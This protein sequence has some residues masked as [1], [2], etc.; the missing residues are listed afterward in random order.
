[1]V[2]HAHMRPTRLVTA[3][4]L[5]AMGEGRRELIYGVVVEMTA[6]GRRHSRIAAAMVGRLG[7]FA[8]SHGLGEVLGADGGFRLARKPDLV[9][10]PD[11]SFVAAARLA[12][13]SE[14]AYV[15]FAPD[16]AV[17]VISPDDS[18]REVEEK[19]AMWLWH[20]SRLV[21][22]VDPDEKTVTVHRA[23]GSRTTLGSADTLSGEDVLPG[24]ELPVASVF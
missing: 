3:E 15:P 11:A 13:V 20:G 4:E 17:E 6:S 14:T 9:R 8:G 1:M 21:W 16:L 24:F 10:V 2:Y 7:E 23:D 18:R 12:G 19:A 22:V 5:L